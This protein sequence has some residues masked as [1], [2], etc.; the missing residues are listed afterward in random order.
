M[1]SENES[2]F[3]AGVISG[4]ELL[5]LEK[6]E[7]LEARIEEL[8]SYRRTPNQMRDAITRAE[9]RELEAL[10]EVDE[11]KDLLSLFEFRCPV[12]RE[13]T[14][15]AYWGP[16]PELLKDVVD[17]SKRVYPIEEGNNG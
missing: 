2:K 7:R 1:P 15:Y 8:E 17:T 3:V 10:Q 6:I 12:T 13:T 9:Q 5:L 11:L 4:K 16:D 14:A